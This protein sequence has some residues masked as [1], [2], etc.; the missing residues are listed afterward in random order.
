MLPSRAAH[1][2][3]LAAVALAIAIGCGTSESTGTDTSTFCDASSAAATA[4][5]ATA[6]GCD[7]TLTSQCTKLDAVLNRTLLAASRDCLQSGICGAS[8]CL[9]R[10]QTTT[11]ALTAH[12]TLAKD[13]CATCA[14][15]LPSCTTQFYARSGNAPGSAVLP[16]SESI[17]A[18]VDKACTTDASCAS[19]FAT[20]ASGTLA[21]ATAGLLSSDVAACLATSFQTDTSDP[22]TTPG[23][24][25]TV[26][27]CN[28]GNCQGC[29]R[30]DKCETG[31]AGAG[32]GVGAVSCQTCSGAQSCSDGV[33]REPCSADNCPGCCSS[34]GLCVDGTASAA[35]GT[36]GAACESCSEKGSTYVCSE[37]QCID[38]SCAA[39][40]LTGCCDTNGCRP[41]TAATGCG[42][43][44]HACVNCGSGNACEPTARTCHLDLD[45][46][47][48]FYAYSAVLPM[49]KPSGGSWDLFGGL[50]DPYVIVYSSGTHAQTTALTDTTTPTWNQV[51]LKNVKASQY[52]S[53]MS[54]NVWDQDLGFGD[55]DDLMGG[56]AMTVYQANFDGRLYYW[57]C[58]Q[59]ATQGAVRITG[60]FLK[61]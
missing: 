49:T 55:S 59:T 6:T 1:H 40:C 3:T 28:P 51:T 25:V 26:A 47:W 36:G 48:D 34:D 8:S 14:P 16:Y 60:R 58:P 45:S 50:P 44:G 4:C 38:T 43:N 17:V 27:Q 54:F 9:T 31:D 42:N 15:G 23:G 35:C 20:C 33:C 39:T 18:A 13:Y 37:Q 52:L 30:D 61:H 22:N 24:G 5:A 32:C 7:G 53:S 19:T 57:T 2:L 56:C 21:T 11:K 46:T 12:A 41:G 10:G 29:C